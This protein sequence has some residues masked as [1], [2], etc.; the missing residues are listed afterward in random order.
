MVQTC[1]FDLL[2]CKFVSILENR[3]TFKSQVSLLLVFGSITSNLG[4][5]IIEFKKIN[6]LFTLFKLFCKLVMITIICWDNE[7]SVFSM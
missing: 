7:W 6:C 4:E 2:L 3:L 1:R 5:F